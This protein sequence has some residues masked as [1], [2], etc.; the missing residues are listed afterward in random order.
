MACQPARWR[1]GEFPV[2]ASNVPFTTTAPSRSTNST[3]TS[4]RSCRG[5]KPR[6]GAEIDSAAGGVPVVLGGIPRLAVRRVVP[7]VPHS[8]QRGLYDS[9]NGDLHWCLR[10]DYSSNGHHS[11][12]QLPPPG[13]VQRTSSIEERRNSFLERVRKGTATH[14]LSLQREKPLDTFQLDTR[15]RS[16][17]LAGW[18]PSSTTSSL[19][20]RR[21]RW[22]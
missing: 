20:R 11:N 22:A 12:R 8:V 3:A 14:F 10:L 5:W 1:P 16:Q 13:A 6:T 18:P 21:E 7:R 4:E 2:S 17:P 9:L 19:T 15:A